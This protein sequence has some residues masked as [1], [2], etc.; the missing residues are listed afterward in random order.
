MFVIC[1]RGTR[2]RLIR[3]P[4]HTGPILNSSPVPRPRSKLHTTIRICNRL[5]RIRCHTA[6]PKPSSLSSTRLP[7]SPSSLPSSQSFRLLLPPPPLPLLF[8]L[9]LPHPLSNQIPNLLTP[10][11]QFVCWWPRSW[12]IEE[13]RFA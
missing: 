3:V 11:H 12:L 10:N 5:S 6:C 2:V 13:I 7:Y 1:R 9:A 8:A 4:S